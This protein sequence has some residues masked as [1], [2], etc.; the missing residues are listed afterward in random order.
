MAAK[1]VRRISKGRGG[2]TKPDCNDFLAKL[3]K[4]TVLQLKTGCQGHNGIFHLI[5]D[6]HFRHVRRGFREDDASEKLNA[7]GC[8]LKV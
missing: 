7:Y 3:I 8:L 4:L 5:E 2:T 6:P 1:I